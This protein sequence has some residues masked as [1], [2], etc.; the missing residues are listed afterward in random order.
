MILLQNARNDNRRFARR[1][2]RHKFG[3]TNALAAK[4]RHLPAPVGFS[5]RG[6]TLGGV[7]AAL[8]NRP[9]R[10]FLQRNQF[11]FFL[12]V[13]AQLRDALFQFRRH[14]RRHHF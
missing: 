11:Y 12:T 1:C 3:R 13:V 10:L 7:V 5:T 2:V 8:L 6:G 4:S 9:L 14:I